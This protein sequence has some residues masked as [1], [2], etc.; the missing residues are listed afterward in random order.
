MAFLLTAL[1][2]QHAVPRHPHPSH[3]HTGPLRVVRPFL[4]SAARGHRPGAPPPED[5]TGGQGQGSKRRSPNGRLED[6]EGQKTKRCRAYDVAFKFNPAGL[7]KLQADTGVPGLTRG[8]M[9]RPGAAQGDAPLRAQR[10]RYHKYASAP[11]PADSDDDEGSGSSDNE[12]EEGP[13]TRSM[14]SAATAAD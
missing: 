11:R 10:G 5:I 14:A 9:G 4:F 6:W 13:V 7:R 3:I 1:V 2:L 12:E 8:W